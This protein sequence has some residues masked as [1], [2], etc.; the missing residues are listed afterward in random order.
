MN[1]GERMSSR[2]Y[3]ITNDINDKIY[4]GKTKLSIQK[5]FSQHCNDSQKRTEEHRPLYSAMRKYGIEHFTISLIEECSDEEASQ[6]EIYWI[7]YYEGYEKGYNATL[8]GD[9]TPFIDP[10]EILRLWTEGK[11]LQEIA[12]VTNHDK[13][14]IS[15]LLKDQGV[16]SSELIN[17]GRA[18]LEKKVYMLDKETGEQLNCFESTRAA[19]RFLIQEK[20]LN[21][22]SESG[23]SSHISEVCRGIRK[24]TLGYKWSYM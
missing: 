16:K 7:K 3:K 4:V 9:G 22:K 23:Y 8:G 2:I 14:W 20:S 17:R 1:R 13:G 24:S 18:A 19:A 21:P 6:K 11:S 12:K 5:R 15:A 10:K